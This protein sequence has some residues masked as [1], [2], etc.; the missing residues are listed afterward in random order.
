MSAASIKQ[1]Y[2][3][4]A[5]AL[6]TGCLTSFNLPVSFAV[7]QHSYT[8]AFE[9]YV[10]ELRQCMTILDVADHLGITWWKV[11]D[12]ESRYLTRHFSK[13][14]LKHLRCLAIDEISIGKGQ[15]YVTVVLDLESGAI[16]HV[17]K[18]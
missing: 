13:P 15:R 6:S 14:K 3:L 11:K 5:A 18:G 10:L 2:L 9:R 4:S 17:G 7:P 12:I 8:R 1:I 16:V